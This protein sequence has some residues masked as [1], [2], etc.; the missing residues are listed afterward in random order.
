METDARAGLRVPP[1][2]QLLLRIGF[3]HVYK[4][5]V[6]LHHQRRFHD[7]HH[8]ANDQ[9]RVGCQRS[10]RP[11]HHEE[12]VLSLHGYIRFGE[13]QKSGIA[14]IR[15]WKLICRQWQFDPFPPDS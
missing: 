7:H 3:A 11:G 8:V 15:L 12:L 2:H 14:F 9:S 6:C 5:A 10:V 1:A 4:Q 13:D